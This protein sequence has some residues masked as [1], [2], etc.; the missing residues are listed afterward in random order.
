MAGADSQ[1]DA[2]EEKKAECG[3]KK[4]K[5]GAG[6]GGRSEL[7]PWP[8]FINERLEM[9]N[10]LKAEHDALLAERAANDSKPIKVTLPDGKQVDAESWKTTPYQIACG[11]RYVSVL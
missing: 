9:Y 10:K 6:D 3:K 7:S 11:I 1:V 8:A 5:E 2:R 4:M